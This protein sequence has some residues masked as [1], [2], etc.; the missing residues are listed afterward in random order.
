MRNPWGSSEWEGDYA[1]DGDQFATLEKYFADKKVTNYKE[2]GAFFAD[3][4]KIYPQLSNLDLGYGQES[5][6][7][8]V[9]HDEW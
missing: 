8:V 1:K 5:S 2:D 3:W 4:S 6:I 7:S 9:D